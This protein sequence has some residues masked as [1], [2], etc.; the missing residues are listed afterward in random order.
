MKKEFFSFKK[1]SHDYL[2]SKKSNTV[3]RTY[4]WNNKGGAIYRMV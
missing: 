1:A 4:I 2:G 3:P